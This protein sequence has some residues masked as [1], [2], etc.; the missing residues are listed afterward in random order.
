MECQCLMFGFIEIDRLLQGREIAMDRGAL[1][2]E[3]AP[4]TQS[5]HVTKRM[6]CSF[7][8]AGRVDP[9]TLRAGAKSIEFGTH[10]A[11]PAGI[12]AR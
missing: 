9:R 5:K 1:K 6:V 2:T 7:N 3:F 10:P 4:I 12:A 8:Q 11:R